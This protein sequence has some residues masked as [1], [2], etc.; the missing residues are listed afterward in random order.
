MNVFTGLIILFSTKYLFTAAFLIPYVVML[1][2]AGL[3]LFFMELALGQ[4]A[5]LGPNI[6]FPKLSPVM[7]GKRDSYKLIDFTHLYPGS[8]IHIHKYNGVVLTL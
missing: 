2:L 6:L 4:Y 8:L 7:G 5:S 1:L 3:P